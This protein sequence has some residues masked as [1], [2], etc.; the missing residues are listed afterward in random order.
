M[1]IG[2]LVGRRARCLRHVARGDSV[3]DTGPMRTY[4][5]VICAAR[6]ALGD[7]LVRV[8]RLV[9]AH[10]ARIAACE[11]ASPYVAAGAVV[12]WSARGTG[13]RRLGR[14]WRGTFI[15]DGSGDGLSPAVTARRPRLP[16][17]P[18]P[19]RQPTRHL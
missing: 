2:V 6:P 18:L 5:V 9:R 3:A 17:R 10:C 12:Q 1:S 7:E 16:Q 15:P 14:R 11:L 4:Q 13:V 8:S 19:G